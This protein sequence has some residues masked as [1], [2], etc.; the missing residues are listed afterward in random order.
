M[1]V[2]R[3]VASAFFLCLFIAV[4]FADPEYQ[5]A[6]PESPAQAYLGSSS[7]TVLRPTNPRALA[8]ALINAI[9]TAGKVKQGLSVDFTPWTL[10]PGFK[11]DLNSYQANSSIYLI[12]NTQISLAT[13]KTSGDTATTEFSAGL[14][15]LFF[16]YGDPMYSKY[17][18]DGLH[19]QAKA[20]CVLPNQPGSPI[21]T[22]CSEKLNLELRKKWLDQNWNRA[23][24]AVGLA[25]GLRLP[26]SEIKEQK[27]SGF[28]LWGTWAFPIYTWGQSL[29]QVNY[30]RRESAHDSL[31]ANL[32]YLAG[33]A[34]AGTSKWN[35][36]L[37]YSDRIR[38]EKIVD[39]I[40]FVNPTSQWTGGI[41]FLA[42]Q[43]FWISTGVGYIFD[44]LEE[45]ESTVLAFNLIWDISSGPRFNKP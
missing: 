23:S 41:E 44:N 4:P 37:E 2:H 18:T 25:L 35:V 24:L 42:A 31:Q 21:D 20:S 30:R 1:R 26:D 7:G 5:Y 27:Y 11:A 29:V 17:F 34:Y 10:I 43:G 13:A 36:F 40:S 45:P 16:D 6:V 15:L 9:D 33:K 38:I 14:R 28:S 3:A 22:A 8:S 12:S 19:E 32:L 39:G